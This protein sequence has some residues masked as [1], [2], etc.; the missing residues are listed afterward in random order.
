[1]DGP[2][3][4]LQAMNTQSIIDTLRQHATSSRHPL[5]FGVMLGVGDG[6]SAVEILQ[7]FPRL[8]LHLIDPWADGFP[9]EEKYQS[10]IDATEN[11]VTA[12]RCWIRRRTP[13]SVAGRYRGERLD[14]VLVNVPAVQHALNLWWPHTLDGA[15]LLGSQGFDQAVEFCTHGQGAM[16]ESLIP[17]NGGEK[18][19][20]IVKQPMPVNSAT[21]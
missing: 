4:I 14:L 13:E 10:A 17:S 20:W 5:H 3:G 6:S 16:L 11:Y 8:F 9:D 18:L 7:A 15:I 19:W 2:L 1:M 21:Q 12:S